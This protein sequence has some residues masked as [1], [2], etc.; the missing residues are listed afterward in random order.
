MSGYRQTFLHCRSNDG[1]KSDHYSDYIIV[2]ISPAR[3]SYQEDIVCGLALV[4]YKEKRILYLDV[5]C[6]RQEERGQNWSVGWQMWNAITRIQNSL[7]NENKTVEEIRL[8]ALAPTSEPNHKLRDIYSKTGFTLHENQCNHIPC[9]KTTREGKQIT[10]CRGNKWSRN[11][12]LTQQKCA[13]GQTSMSKCVDD[14]A[15][16]LFSP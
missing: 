14:E 2:S 16:S 15:M 9:Y 10:E 13:P 8:C 5:I 4:Q 7:R 3:E 12:R 6:S 11:P 1:K